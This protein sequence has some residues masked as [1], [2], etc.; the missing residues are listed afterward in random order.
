[1]MQVIAHKAARKPKLGTGRGGLKSRIKK[2]R[3]KIKWSQEE[4][5]T[6]LHLESKSTIARYESGQREPGGMLRRKIIR[7][8][9]LV[10][11][12]TVQAA[13][14][15]FKGKL[16]PF[17]KSP[18]GPFATKPDGNF[19]PGDLGDEAFRSAPR[20]IDGDK[21]APGN[22]PPGKTGKKE[23][24]E[25]RLASS[26]GSSSLSIQDS[27]EV[28]ISGTKNGT[29]N[30]Q[31]ACRETDEIL[32]R[33]D[34]KA[35]ANASFRCRFCGKVLDS[36][37]N[38]FGQLID[39][40]VVKLAEAAREGLKDDYS[41]MLL[42]CAHSIYGRDAAFLRTMSQAGYLQDRYLPAKETESPSCPYCGAR[43]KPGK[44]HYSDFKS[45]TIGRFLRLFG[46]APLS[47]TA[48]D[49]VFDALKVFSPRAQGKL[50]TA[51]INAGI[52]E[53][54]LPRIEKADGDLKYKTLCAYCGKW[55][56]DWTVSVDDSL[57]AKYIC[58]DCIEDDRG[59]TRTRRPRKGANE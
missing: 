17:N 5:A 23:G 1:M 49:A 8:V 33:L 59:Y 28:L 43:I 6:F 15:E 55:K 16:L 34:A 20:M 58:E 50:K 30:Q 12:L 48:I 19:P 26:G 52:S 9:R 42:R 47:L 31:R 56:W 4:L 27:S 32:A 35:R 25:R 22:F 29:G 7:W 40:L 53:N 21:V 11:R 54:H 14:D 51:L 46:Q 39:T 44:L 57:V 3:N 36:A 24:G 13:K 41:S 2:A 38:Y 10:E 45:F 37:E 18:Q